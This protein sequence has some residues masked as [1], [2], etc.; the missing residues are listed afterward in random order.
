MDYISVTK[1][2][3]VT[4]L[5]VSLGFLFH[6]SHYERMAREMIG[7]PSGFILGGVLPVLVGSV[8]INFPDSYIQGWPI[9]TY[10][11]WVLFAVGVLRIW[12]IHWWINILKA[13]MAFVPVLFA[14]F[15]LIFG[16]LL[17]YAGFVVPLYSQY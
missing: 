9:L 16:C 2:F 11:G 13:N 14:V 5:V 4:T 1:A 3:G 17:C 10:I 12:C 6:L 8:I 15:G 7:H